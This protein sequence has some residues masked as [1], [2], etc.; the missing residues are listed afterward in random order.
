MRILIRSDACFYSLPVNIAGASVFPKLARDKCRRSG[1][2]SGPLSPHSPGVLGRRW[3]SREVGD[4]DL[5][6]MSVGVG[7]FLRKWGMAC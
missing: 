1:Q 4:E 2:W 7:V 6:G 3:T 5:G